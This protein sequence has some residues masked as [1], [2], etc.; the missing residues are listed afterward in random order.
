[1]EQAK[2]RIYICLIT[3]VVIA[4]LVGGFYYFDMRSREQNLENGVLITAVPFGAIK[5]VGD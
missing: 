5:Y 1:M 4:I 2:K 3:A